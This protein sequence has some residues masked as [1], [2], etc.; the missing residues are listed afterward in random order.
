MDVSLKAAD[1]LAARG[2]DAEVLDLRSLS[3]L[4]ESAILES[5]ARTHHLVVVHE[6]HRRLGPGAEISAICMERGFDYLDGPV[7]RVGALDNPIPYGPGVLEVFPSVE[8]VMTAVDRTL[9]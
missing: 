4:D 7:Q 9:E 6:A 5:L 2:V 3:P 1:A 8:R